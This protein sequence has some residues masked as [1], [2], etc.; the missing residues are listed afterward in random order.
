MSQILPEAIERYLSTLNRRGDPVLDAMAVEGHRRD[1]P[2]VHPETG[3]LLQ[4]PAARPTHLDSSTWPTVPPTITWPSSTD[5][6]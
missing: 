5:C 1:L 3:R 2:V 4:S 6:A